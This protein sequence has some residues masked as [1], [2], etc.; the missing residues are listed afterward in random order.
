MYSKGAI[1]AAASGYRAVEIAVKF[2]RLLNVLPVR[3]MSFMSK[4][5]AMTFRDQVCKSSSLQQQVRAAIESGKD[6]TEAVRLGKSCGCEFTADEAA[7][8]LQNMGSDELSEFELEMVAGGAGKG[9]L[10]RTG[11]VGQG[12]AGGIITT[13]TGNIAGRSGGAFYGW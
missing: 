3:E 1:S 11:R 13:G 2:G 8:V 9:G 12:G 7:E 5:A 6:L 4:E 10:G